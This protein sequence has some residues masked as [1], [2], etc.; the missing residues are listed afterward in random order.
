MWGLTLNSVT[1]VNLILAISLVVDYTIHIVHR[2]LQLKHDED[3]KHRL[4]QHSLVEAQFSGPEHSAKQVWGVL[5]NG[6]TPSGQTPNDEVS[7]SRAISDSAVETPSVRLFQKVFGEMGVNVLYGGLTTFA[8]VSMLFFA[9]SYIFSCFFKMFTGIV[10]FGV[11]H[12]LCVTPVVLSFL[13]TTPAAVY[14]GPQAR[15]T[16]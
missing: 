8:G 11:F 2:Y 16:P 10:F 1:L 15:E 9:G 12:G 4:A 6:Q 14:T 5:K 7:T 3:E 13:Y